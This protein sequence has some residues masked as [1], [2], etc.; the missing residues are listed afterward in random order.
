MTRLAGFLSAFWAA[1]ALT[2]T[3][4]AMAAVQPDADSYGAHAFDR[5]MWPN[6]A[7]SG[8]HGEEMQPA[9]PPDVEDLTEP[10]PTQ[11]PTGKRRLKTR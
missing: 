2:G 9:P 7:A 3:L 5:G 6:L 8:R 4:P 1:L 11:P 10:D